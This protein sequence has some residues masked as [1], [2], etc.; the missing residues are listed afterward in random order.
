MSKAHRMLGLVVVVAMLATGCAS[1]ARPAASPAPSRS[2]AHFP[3]TITDADGVRVTIASAPRR[4]VTFAPS[5]T[6]IV[7]A[8]GLGSKLVG[9][10]GSYD[11]YPAAATKLPRVSDSS[12]VAPDLEKV[13]ALHPDVFLAISGGEAWKARLRSLGVPVFSV[14]ATTLPGVLASIRTI[15]EITGALQAA[16]SLTD[17]MA[18]QV[19]AIETKVAAEP[20]VSCFFEVYYPPLYTV[21]PGSFI[22][23]MLQRAGCDPVTSGANASYPTWS[24]ERLVR[25]PP[26]VYLVSSNPGVTLARVKSRPGFDGISAVHQGRVYIVN[27]DLIS[28]PGPRIV[29]GLLLL[30]EALHP[31]AFPAAA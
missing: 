8:L 9:V 15:G 24:V 1:H 18:A 29:Q 20:R 6:E 25:H 17:R 13:V 31:G 16:V 4:I 28:R 22:Y 7:Y 23:D 19:K 21:G 11:N 3:M 30:A 26:E 2:T 12:G 5:N 10:S 14:N 27:S